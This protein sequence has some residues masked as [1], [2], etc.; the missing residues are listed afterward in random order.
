[1]IFILPKDRILRSLSK[2]CRRLRW[3][4]NIPDR[5]RDSISF[6][7]IALCIFSISGCIRLWIWSWIASSLLWREICRIDCGIA[8]V[9]DCFE[10]QSKVEVVWFSKIGSFFLR[11][12]VQKRF[13]LLEIR[14]LKDIFFFIFMRKKYYVWCS[15]CSTD[16]DKI[17]LMI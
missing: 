8:L 9:Q 10:S 16:I 1:M 14:A 6:A 11:E 7:W 4:R 17:Y 2:D 12:F 5:S 13:C 15:Y 3:S